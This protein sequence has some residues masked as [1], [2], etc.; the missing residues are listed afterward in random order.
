MINYNTLSGIK[1]LY[2]EDGNDSL[3]GGT[4]ADTLDGGDGNDYLSGDNGND[5]LLGGVGEDSINGGP[6][7]DLIY[8][9]AGNDSVNFL[10]DTG[11]DTVYGGS[12]DDLINYNTISGNKTLYGEDGNDS[13]YGGTGADTLNGGTGNDLLFGGDGNDYF[14]ASTGSDTIQGG[15]GTNILILPGSVMDYEAAT[16]LPT[17]YI[18]LTDTISGRGGTLRVRDI[19][20][21]NFS[22]TYRTNLNVTIPSVRVTTPSFIE[23]ELGTQ[24]IVISLSTPATSTIKI[25]LQSEGSGLASGGSDYAVVNQIIQFEAGSKSQSI[26]VTIIDDNLFEPTEFFY[27]SASKASTSSEV[28]ITQP[29][30]QIFIYDNDSPYSNLPSDPYR[31][32]QWHLYDA[33]GV[34]VFRVWPQYTGRGIVVGIFD[35]GIDSVHPDLKENLNKP[36]GR[37]ASDLSSGGDPILPTDNHGTMVAGLVGA[38]RNGVGVVGVAY[39]SNLVSVYSPLLINNLSNEISNAYKYFHGKVDII[40]DSWGLGNLFDFGSNYA[41][42][43]NFLT[44][45][46]SSAANNLAALATTGRNGLGVIVVQAAGNS[47]DRGDETNLHNFQNSRF[48]TTVAATDYF[49]N[50]ST[51]SSTGSSILVA[52]PGGAPDRALGIWTTDRSGIL[53]TTINDYASNSGTSFSGPLVAGV[54]ALILQAN[55]SL[56][57]RDVQ[58]ILAISARNISSN[59][60]LWE[61]NGAKTWNNGGFRYSLYDTAEGEFHP[62]GFGNIDARAAVRLAESWSKSST[63]SNLLKV[64]STKSVNQGIPDNSSGGL[65][66]TISIENHMDIE[67]IEVYPII[68]HSYIGDLQMTLLSPSGLSFSVLLNRPGK[69]SSNPLS[70]GSA[71]DNINFVFSTVAH[72]GEDSFGRWTLLVSDLAAGDV[73]VLDSWEIRF[74]GSPSSNDNSYFYTDDFST[75]SSVN[76]SNRSV[77]SDSSGY[78]TINAAAVSGNVSIDLRQ[79]GSPSLIGSSA[80]S[81]SPGTLVE[82]VVTGD[83]SDS[84]Y[85]NAQDNHLS[86]MRG[87]DTLYGQSGNDVLLGGDGNDLLDGGTGADTLYGSQGIDTFVLRPGD[88]GASEALADVITDFQDGTDLLFLT[89]AITSPIQLSLTA[90]SGSYAGGTFI[91]YGAE[92]LV[93][94]VGVTPSQLTFADFTG[95]GG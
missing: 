78:D 49:G 76:T 89:G 36:L 58:Q 5:Y 75:V 28:I 72:L 54:V 32:F 22:D 73:G 81:L 64:V 77:L 90:G 2:G 50:R 39:D 46:W 33:T 17:G 57:Y 74:Y 83:G 29:K 35:Q 1:T 16:D 88:G 9:D 8:G 55:P 3:Y 79:S 14:I 48:I 19:Q 93:F 66:S 67:R 21:F 25:L 42:T 18:I 85:G 62:L 61:Y 65:I 94:I 59:N 87:D 7:N 44:A 26:P 52:A 70:F 41:F 43:D 37:N 84:I 10:A 91:K 53:G 86:G 15:G 27:I 24:N 80:F 38:A 30:L 12:G 11:N 34:N 20:Y 71:Q 13:L 51:Y 4:S 56:G 60:Y 23:G 31:Q 40:N 68:R 6:G 92:F 69:L 82:R 95:G 47:Q 45:A 63:E